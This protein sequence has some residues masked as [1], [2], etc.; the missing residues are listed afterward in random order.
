[1]CLPISK[2]VLYI[3]N[4]DEENAEVVLDEENLITI[5][6]DG[7]VLTR[8]GRNW[9]VS[10]TRNRASIMHGILPMLKIDLTYQF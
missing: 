9:K 8:N 1:M 7:S 10:H 2:E 5:P 6:L 3:Y 4:R